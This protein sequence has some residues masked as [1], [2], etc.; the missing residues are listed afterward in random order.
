MLYFRCQW[1]TQIVTCTSDW[2]SINQRFPGL[3][4]SVWLIWWS[5]SQNSGNPEPIYYKG[6]NPG[7]ARQKRCLG[8]DMR[9]T[10]EA[11][12]SSPRATLSP[13]LHVFTRP[14]AL[15]TPLFWV[16]GRLHY[17]G[18]MNCIISHWWLNAISSSLT[19]RRLGVG[20]KVPTLQS[21]LQNSP[22]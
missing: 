21:C 2:W 14:E 5:D 4:P 17:T 13:Y 1:Q 15:Q 19:P 9:K 6:Y 10:R 7:P 18:I 8:Q 12:V 20:R 16:W 3:P 11:T 22:H